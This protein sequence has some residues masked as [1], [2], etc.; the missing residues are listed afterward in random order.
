VVTSSFGK[1]LRMLA[2]REFTATARNKPLLA[3]RFG[4]TIMLNLIFGAI[5]WGSGNRDD[6][7]SGNFNS[8]FGAVTM[9]SISSMMGAVQP[10]LLNFPT[11]RP[12]FMREYST[13]TYRTAPYFISK[14]MVELPLCLAQSCVQYLVVY[15]MVGFQGQFYKLVFSAWMLGI[16]SA[17]TAV[18][19]GCA[20]SSIKTA[21]ELMPLTMVPQMLFAG[22][23]IKTSQI[24]VLLRWAQYLC[25]LKYAMNLIILA[26][27]DSTLASCQGE[28]AKQCARIKSSNDIDD[29]SELLSW[30]VLIALFV[31]FRTVGAITLAA[32]SSK[33]Y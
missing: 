4:V 25:A 18:V 3:G 16:T 10:V 28:A 27:F 32:K 29:S 26:E 23:F 6:S 12:M 21:M 9:I 14:A 20:V 11:E 5:F 24:P 15:W 22:F 8:H 17:S 19:L 2:S 1:Q 33:F 30:V 13:G 31:S 7:I